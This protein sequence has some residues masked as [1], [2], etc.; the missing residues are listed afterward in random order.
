MGGA[1][2]VTAFAQTGGLLVSTSQLYDEAA[3]SQKSTIHVWTIADWKEE[4]V[5]DDGE[6]VRELLIHNGK[7]LTISSGSTKVWTVGSWVQEGVMSS[8]RQCGLVHGDIAV[9]GGGIM[10]LHHV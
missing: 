3:C 7:L 1:G 9:F 6:S 2:T 4:R 5:F 10:N 8:A